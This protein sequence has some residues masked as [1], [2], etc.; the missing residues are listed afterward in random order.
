MKII[1]CRDELVKN[2]LMN[3]SNAGYMIMFAFP[4]DEDGHYYEVLARKGAEFACWQFNAHNGKDA[5]YYGH[6]FDN[7]FRAF[8]FLEEV[9]NSHTT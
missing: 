8:N 3:G 7:I 5:F 2:D 9:V 4:L 6:Y 1:E